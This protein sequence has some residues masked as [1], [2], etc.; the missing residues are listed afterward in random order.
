[1]SKI[2]AQQ[3]SLCYNFNHHKKESKHVNK[4]NQINCKQ[5]TLIYQ[6]RETRIQNITIAQT[7]N[8][9]MYKY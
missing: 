8:D 1:M 2:G 4:N 3:S 6:K 7:H 9:G 5:G